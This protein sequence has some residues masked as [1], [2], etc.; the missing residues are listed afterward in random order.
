MPPTIPQTHELGITVKGM[1]NAIRPMQNGGF[2]FNISTDSAFI[3]VFAKENG[4]KQGDLYHAQLRQLRIGK[5]NNFQA[6]EAKRLN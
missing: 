3:T 6:N 4:L 1:V 2:M 5:Y